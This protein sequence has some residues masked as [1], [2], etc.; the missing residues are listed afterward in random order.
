MFSDEMNLP[1][2]CCILKFPK[3]FH[4]LY[5]ISHTPAT[6]TG[7]VD[8]RVNLGRDYMTAQGGQVF[9]VQVLVRTKIFLV[10]V[11]DPVFSK[12][13]YSAYTQDHF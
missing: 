2:I 6:Y 1:Q 3:Y 9:S 8:S 13:A 4:T 12:I 5:F 10:P 11:P 7:S